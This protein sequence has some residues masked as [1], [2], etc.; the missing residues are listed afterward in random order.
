MTA[1]ELKS[2]DYF[3]PTLKVCKL[4]EKEY[5]ELLETTQ[6]PLKNDVL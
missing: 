4:L 1:F 5:A 3:T 6:K 2:K